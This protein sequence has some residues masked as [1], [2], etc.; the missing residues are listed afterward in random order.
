MALTR[1]Q[2]ILGTGLAGAGALLGRNGA[3]AQTAPPTGRVVTKGR[4]KQSVSWW[5][6]QRIRPEGRERPLPEFARAVKE[7]G[8]TAI[9]LL[10]EDEWPM[11]RDLG[12][13]CS[14]GYGG[15]GTIPDG[16]NNKANHDTIVKGL[17][18][19]LPKAAQMG[20]PNL[21][22]F[23]GNRKGM[24]DPEGLDNC[25]VGLNRIKPMA[26]AAGVTV[27]IEVLNSKVDHKDYL[28]DRSAYGFQV[29]KA[30]GSP[31]IKVL[32]DIYHMQIMEGDII[33]TVRDNHQWIAHYHTGG[34]PGRHELDET[35][36][37]QWRSV[38]AAI[39][40]TG[41]T[42]YVAHEFVPTRDPLTSL[43]EAVALCDV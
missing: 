41:F 30:V 29:V 14:M 35:Q 21:I 22:T 38:C 5:C 39:A 12:L 13:V 23:F 8:L 10:K 26:E 7:M 31:K 40:D 4:L 28:G 24:P 16:L 34:V 25:V 1:R 15:G 11:V 43:R 9:D 32:F 42:G 37:L 18:K 6:Y 20:V 33:R 3:D 27:T 19:T 36:E 2:A 17:E